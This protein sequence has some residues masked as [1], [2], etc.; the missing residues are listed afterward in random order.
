MVSKVQERIYAE[1]AIELLAVDWTLQDIPE[2]LDF[3]VRTENFRF[4]LEVRNVFAGGEET[5]GS[6]RRRKESINGRLIR[7]LAERYYAVGGR[8]ITAQFLGKVADVNVNQVAQQLLVASAPLQSWERTTLHIGKVKV[9]LTAL[10]SSAGRYLRWMVVSDRVGWARK[11]TCEELQAAIDRKKENL[12]LYR[13]KYPEI[14]LLLV[15]DR[16]LNSGRLLQDEEIIVNNPGFRRIYF[17][18]YPEAICRVG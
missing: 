15:A 18:S 13:A 7:S 6:P 14:D 10:P 1:K 5:Y 17:M 12:S 8:P 2:P 3:E 16:L 4:G 9:I 11:V